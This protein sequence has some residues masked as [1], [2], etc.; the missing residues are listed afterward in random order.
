M[1]R[2]AALTLVALICSTSST[3]AQPASKT[4][5]AAAHLIGTWRLVSLQSDS[6]S[7]LVNR[8]PHPIGLIYYDSTGH[9]AVQIQPDRRRASW[10]PTQLPSPQQAADAVNGYTAYFGTYSIDEK[11]HTVTHHRAGA[12]NLDVVDYVRR[13]EFD[14]NDRLTLIPVD[15]PGTKL[16]WERVK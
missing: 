5:G 15:R 10:P 6:A 14:G 4:A 12:L 3:S 8:G 13:Y 1:R 16:V 11:A 9:M 2:S 7:H